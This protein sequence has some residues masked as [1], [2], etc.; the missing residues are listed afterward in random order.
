M[1][2]RGEEGLQK[3]IIARLIHF[4]AEVPYRKYPLALLD[5][6]TM[7][8]DGARLFGRGKKAGLLTLLQEQGGGSLVIKR[9]NKVGLSKAVK[10]YE[11]DAR[12][13]GLVRFRFA[14]ILLLK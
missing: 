14:A 3:E 5:A 12:G 13:L 9:A 10:S 2:V 1:F 8:T 6:S 11:R 4:D 7:D